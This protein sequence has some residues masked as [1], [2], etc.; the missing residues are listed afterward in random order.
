MTCHHFI[1][2]T[3]IWITVPSLAF[4]DP[5]ET[6]WVLQKD[7]P[8]L[9]GGSREINTATTGNWRVSLQSPGWL[10]PMASRLRSI[11]QTSSGSQPTAGTGC[12]NSAAISPDCFFWG[13]PPSVEDTL[14]RPAPWSRLGRQNLLL[15]SSFRE[16]RNPFDSYWRSLTPPRSG[17]LFEGITFPCSGDWYQ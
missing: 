4:P 15:P 7:P 3:Q 16:D 11:P 13:L 9:S 6:I 1:D 17:F 10:S 2:L 12:H 14:S 8:K 5:A